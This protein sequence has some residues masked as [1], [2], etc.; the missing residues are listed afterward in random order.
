MTRGVA[1]TT[2]SSSGF[3]TSLA[4]QQS[5]HFR[6]SVTACNSN[7]DYY[8]TLGVSPEATQKEIKKA[9]YQ[10]AK[11]YHPDTNKGDNSAQKKF[12]DVSEAYECLSD[13][14]KRKQY[15]AFKDGGF[16]GG[17]DPFGG[18]GGAAGG[19]AG[20]W[21]FQSQMN[22]EDLFKTIFGDRANPFND[23]GGS[24]HFD[25]GGAASP[26]EYQMNLTFI[27]AAKGVEKE[28]KVNIL[29]TCETCGGTGNQ[30]G[31]SPDRCTQCSGTGMET[32]STGPFMMRSTCRRCHGKGV[33]NKNPCFA[34]RG[35]GQT[36][37]RKT[38]KVP[39][40][41]GI[42]NGQTVRMQV[43]SREVFIT[44]R[45]EASDYFQ[46][47][48]AD[49]HTDAKISFAQAIFGGNIRLAGV[50]DDLTL[51]IPP[52]TPSH[53]RMKMSGKGLKKVSGYGYGDHYIHIKIDVPKK[54]DEKQLALMTAWAE[55][56]PGT[57][58]TVNG[59]TYTKSGG[60]V[61]MEDDPAG[62]VADLREA[63]EDDDRDNDRQKKDN[64]E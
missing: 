61:A 34:C 5:R 56:E 16:G 6:T 44:F 33:F 41:A 25:F 59:F 46:R 27:E 18:F 50:Y 47:K 8:K 52:N 43:G 62:I 63:L 48:G 4:A 24:P 55:I 49:I 7:K 53:T 13:E 51:Q 54:L 28:L 64:N 40:P 3:N 31:T 14:S 23:G 17:G 20:G 11:K 60:R 2:K 30:A 39:V 36:K 9:Y 19:T 37:Q 12:Q 10:L 58:G 15:D 29:D 45:V 42:E 1:A 32:V 35:A 21:N 26:Q 57:P 22:A 38:V